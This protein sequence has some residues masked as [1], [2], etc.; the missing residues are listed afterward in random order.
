MAAFDHDFAN[1]PGP[2]VDQEIGDLADHSIVSFNVVAS[3]D[4]GASKM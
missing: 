4:A 3:Y 1:H 2:S